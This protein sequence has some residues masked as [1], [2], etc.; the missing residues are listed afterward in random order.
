VA[1]VAHERQ[2]GVEGAPDG[3]LGRLGAELAEVEL[4]D[5]ARRQ[6]RRDLVLVRLEVTR[7]VGIVRDERD[8]SGEGPPGGLEGEDLRD[9]GLGLLEC[10]R[11]DSADGDV[12]ERVLAVD[13]G[14]ERIGRG[15][16]IRRPGQER[17]EEVGARGARK[18]SLGVVGGLAEE[19]DVA[20][21]GGSPVV[22]GEGEEALDGV[23]PGFP[24]AELVDD[25]LV[26]D[27]PGRETLSRPGWRGF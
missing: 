26:G 14:V 11:V 1:D 19:E 4:L 5:A 15:P 27:G 18:A 17:G 23:G 10:G 24:V 6:K 20:G 16:E 3:G 21:R 13:G 9:G 7:A 22:E 8:L 25:G 2:P 12:G